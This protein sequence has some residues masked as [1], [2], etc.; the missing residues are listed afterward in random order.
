MHAAPSP[1]G[2]PPPTGVLWVQTVAARRGG[3]AILA[4]TYGDDWVV[5]EVTQRGALDPTFGNGG[6]TVLPFQGEVTAVVQ[7]PSGR[8]VVAG[9]N[10]GGGCCT[11]DWATAVSAHGRF[12]PAF[13]IHGRE[14]LPRGEDSGVGAVVSEPNG[15]ILVMVGG[16][17]MGCFGVELAMLTPS[18]QP[19]PGFASRLRQFW[20]RLGFGTF[21]GD[22]YVDADGFTLVGA[23]QR[24]CMDTSYSFSAPSAT[25]LIAHF[26]TDGAAVGPTVH[27]PSRMAGATYAFENGADSLIV[28]SPYSN[29]TELTLTAR[30]PDGSL[31]PH[32]GSGGRGLVR[33][34]WS[35][36]SMAWDVMVSISEANPTTIV[37]IATLNGHNELRILRLHV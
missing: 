25:G 9:D 7:E 13:G 2:V 34:P 14:T 28:Q 27:F 24:P 17:N 12:D 35:G 29:P 8:I 26:R 30:R 1:P 16:G 33:T 5:G 20:R 6:W 23:G 4:G 3:G 32:F 22:V 18:G 10:N 31:D 11:Y 15:D 37:V 21:V 36:T 19:V